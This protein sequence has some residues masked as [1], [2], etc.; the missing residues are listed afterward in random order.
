MVRE[1][2]GLNIVSF[3]RENVVPGHSRVDVHGADYFD[4]IGMCGI[5]ETVSGLKE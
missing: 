2:A 4:P 1:Y 3:E 5:G